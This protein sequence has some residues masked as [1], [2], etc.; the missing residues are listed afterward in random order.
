HVAAFLDSV[1][2]SKFNPKE[3]PA[4]T[5]AFW[6]IVNASR[7]PEDGELAD[8]IEALGNP[9]A[10][11][12][13]D[14][15]LHAEPDF[16]TWLRDRRNSRQIPH[17]LESVGYM[18]VRNTTA[19]DGLWKLNKKRQVIYAQRE[20]TLRERIKAAIERTRKSV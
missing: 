11:T 19:K 18:P 7:A 5:E 3:P 4:Q 9:P 14:I 12:L 13:A 20:L 8:A 2:L 17:R 15:I 10:L 6:E 1:D 16:S